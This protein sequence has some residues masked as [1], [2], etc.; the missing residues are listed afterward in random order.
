MRYRTLP[1]TFLKTFGTV[2]WQ[3]YLWLAHVGQDAGVMRASG[4]AAEFGV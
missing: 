1:G 3:F 2:V 4:A